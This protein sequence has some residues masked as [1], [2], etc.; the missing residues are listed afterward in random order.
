MDDRKALCCIEEFYKDV[1]A[2]LS[3]LRVRAVAVDSTQFD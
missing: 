3:A 2:I 1:E